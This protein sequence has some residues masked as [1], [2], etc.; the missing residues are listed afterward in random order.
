MQVRL[1]R[2]PAFRRAL[3]R[4]RLARADRNGNR[5]AAL[6]SISDLNLAAGNVDGA[7]EAWN[8][9]FGADPEAFDVYD[10]YAYHLWQRG[11]WDAAFDA[12]VREE[13]LRRE[14]AAR[15]KLERLPFRLLDRNWTGVIGMMGHPYHDVRNADPLTY[16]SAVEAIVARGGWVVRMGD[17]MLT[18]T[19]LPPMDHVVD[20]AHSDAKSDWMDVFLWA[21]CR[22]L[23]GSCSG[24]AQIPG[25]F[26][27]PVVQTNWCPVA[28]RYWN[29]RDLQIPKL[30]WSDKESRL[31]TFAESIAPPL[32]FA[33]L[34]HHFADAGVRV[35]D[36]TPEELREVVVEMLDRVEGRAIY[37]R[38]D[39]D[40]QG[41][42]DRLEPPVR[43]RIPG[44]GARRGRDFLRRYAALF[45]EPPVRTSS[46]G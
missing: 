15:R 20:Y 22:F 46:T 11:E 39:D 7:L 31:L 27:V 4:R 30:Y 3:A 10:R 8:A 13:T 37:T 26:G 43:Y 21:D 24:P 5:A 38:E 12:W 23:I 44:G 29:A 32:G 6:A 2:S 42:F 19:K 36:N 14:Y 16:A 45:D 35:I 40:L 25:T 18:S 1:A 41:R 9:S 34:P 28:P 33:Q 17:P